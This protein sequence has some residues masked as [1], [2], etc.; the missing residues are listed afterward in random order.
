[1]GQAIEKAGGGTY[2]PWCC[3]AHLCES[4]LKHKNKYHLRCGGE[5]PGESLMLDST[6]LLKDFN[7]ISNLLLKPEP[8]LAT[9][10][11]LL[12]QLLRTDTCHHEQGHI[13]AFNPEGRRKNIFL[14]FI[15]SKGWEALGV[16]LETALSVCTRALPGRTVGGGKTIRSLGK[17]VAA[18]IDRMPKGHL[19]AGH[20][21]EIRNFFNKSG[22]VSAW[23]ICFKL[24]G[25]ERRC[26]VDA[27]S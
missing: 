11:P 18:K 24:E 10:K 20:A 12:W 15:A 5:R 4:S 2:T 1:M 7:S 26:Y 9:S 3:K 6:P 17:A 16:S 14:R 25:K 21:N 8:S 19:H 22:S 13:Q 27:P 23:M